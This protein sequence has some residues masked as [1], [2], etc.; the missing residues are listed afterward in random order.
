MA[1]VS[2]RDLR[3]SYRTRRGLVQAV[4][5][6]SFDLHEGEKLG[7]VGESG[8]GKTTIA[9]AFLAILPPNARAEGEILFRGRDLVGMGEEEIREI[10]WKEIA[11]IPQSAMN[12]LNPVYRVGDQIE[13]IFRKRANLQK[14]EAREKAAELFGLVGLNKTR[15]GD[16][17]HQFSGGMKQR[18]SIAM[19]MALN[20]SLI[21]ADEPTTALDVITQD[22]VL[23]NIYRILRQYNKSMIMIT[24]D[25]SVV[26]EGCDTIAVMYAGQLMEY[27]EI[28][29]VLRSPYNPYT[30]GL[31]NAFPNLRGPKSELISIPG[32]PP[33]LLEHPQGCI[34]RERCPFADGRCAEE[35]PALLPVAEAHFAACHQKERVDELR[36]LGSR[37]ETWAQ[38]G[39]SHAG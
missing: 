4:D 30:L 13:E 18:V 27:G 8:C 16:Y 10:R 24:H 39:K 28:Q 25:I 22:Q 32:Y 31:R 37:K 33:S 19:A 21:V 12:A 34:F 5:G 38:M 1:L 9:K 26:A 36:A 23:Q 35:K 29:S 11:L 17:P 6:I 3:V 14:G 2:V 20:P 7:L 15:L